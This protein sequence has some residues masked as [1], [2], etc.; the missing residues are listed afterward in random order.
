MWAR[1]LCDLGDEKMD[2]EKEGMIWEMYMEGSGCLET[3]VRWDVL[4]KKKGL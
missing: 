3:Q 4:Q 1:E 2:G